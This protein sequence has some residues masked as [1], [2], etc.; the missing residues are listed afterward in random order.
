MPNTE[1]AV[2]LPQLTWFWYH[3]SSWASCHMWGMHSLVSDRRLHESISISTM[4]GRRAWVLSVRM[5]CSGY[6][7]SPPSSSATCITWRSTPMLS[8]RSLADSGK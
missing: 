5:A 6:T 1:Y 3:C 8:I 2:P 4:F 7:S